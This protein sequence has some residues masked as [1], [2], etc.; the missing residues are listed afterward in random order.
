MSEAAGR[1]ETGDAAERLLRSL[2]AQRAER[3]TLLRR[4][5][6]LREALR[7]LGAVLREVGPAPALE[8]AVEW[9]ADALGAVQLARSPS[10]RGFDG[11]RPVGCAVCA[12]EVLP[13]TG[14]RRRGAA[15][16]GGWAW[17]CRACAAEGGH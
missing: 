16:G 15:G 14:T 1:Y 11:W 17:L 8:R 12:G 3:D 2:A 4:E 10:W 6:A 5:R 9:T 7:A 13:G